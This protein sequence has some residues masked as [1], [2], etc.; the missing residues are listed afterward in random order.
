MGSQ[1]AS[2]ALVGVS[3]RPDHSTRVQEEVDRSQVQ[4]LPDVQDTI[5]PERPDKQGDGFSL[6]SF[7]HAQEQQG[8]PAWAPIHPGGNA[9]NLP[10]AATLSR[11][12]AQ[13]VQT[14]RGLSVN[15]PP[16][17]PVVGHLASSVRPR[18]EHNATQR[19]GFEISQSYARANSATF[20]P[21]RPDSRGRSSVNNA[22]SPL[23]HEVPHAS[24]TWPARSQTL[25]PLE[26][27]PTPALVESPHGTTE[28][29]QSTPTRLGG[30]LADLTDEIGASLPFEDEPKGPTA[31]RYVF[32]Q[33]LRREMTEEDFGLQIKNLCRG[34]SLR[35]C[36]TGHLASFGYAVLV[37]SDIHH[38]VSL[39]RRLALNGESDELS[40]FTKT[41]VSARCIAREAFE[42]LVGSESQNPLLSTSEGVLV[43]TLRGPTSTP[44]F[45]P[46]PIL[47]AFGEIRAVK[48]VERNMH[49]VEYWD[50]RAAETA[51]N[52]LAGRE[53]GGARF[54]CSFE[55]KIASTSTLAWESAGAA[56]AELPAAGV[57]STSSARVSTQAAAQTEAPQY[58]PSRWRTRALPSQDIITPSPSPHKGLPYRSEG[59]LDEYRF[60]PLPRSAAASAA[61]GDSPSTHTPPGAAISPSRSLGKGKSP[62][63]AQPGRPGARLPAEYGLVRD[64]KI[65]AG[66]MLNFDRIERG[67]DVRTTLMIKN[68]PNKMKDTEV[69]EYIEEIVGRTYD[70]FYLRCDYSNDCNVGYGFV[71]FVSTAALLNFARARLGTRWNTCG[72]DKLCV[73]SYANIQGKPSLINHFKNSSVLDQDEKRRPKLFITDGPHAGEPEPFPA[74]DDPLRKARSAMNASNVGLFPSAKPVFKI[75]HALQNMHI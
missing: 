8:V 55:P 16:F 44:N 6:A 37:F 48:L 28:S 17:D 75:A 1:N 45:T 39:L 5:H 63:F 59:P 23:R 38:A 43:F 32:L 65:P 40:L 61:I 2:E 46:L 15:P 50:D 62:G 7:Q 19:S 22:P 33:N 74:C 56:Q 10:D 51:M 21:L 18:T 13:G 71:N 41:A 70:F 31:T 64:D 36:F 58:T 68:I 30:T 25:L 69:M 73:L 12:R 60:P 54:G 3:R 35:G 72:S 14:R 29:A 67:L 42:Q 52:V 47:A 11:L 49:I 4:A 20:T 66:N 26:P 57:G 53:S 34:L 9:Y 24:W 27:G